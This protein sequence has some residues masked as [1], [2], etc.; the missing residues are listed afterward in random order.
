MTRFPYD[1]FA[2]DYLQELLSPLGSV[3]TSKDV[4]G[5]VREIDVYFIPSTQSQIDKE[6]LGLLAG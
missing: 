4:V 3:E 5:E 6:T 2:K 1:Q